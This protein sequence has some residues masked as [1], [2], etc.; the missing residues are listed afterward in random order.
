MNWPK[1]RLG[2]V[3][4][5][6]LGKTPPR[7][8]ARM[9]D[10]THSKGCV[11]SS[12]ADM[13]NLENGC[14][15]DTKEYIS[16]TAVEE[17]DI[18]VVKKGTL[19][20]SFKLTLGR[21]AIAGRDLYTNEAIA[22]LP[23]RDAYAGKVDIDYL[24]TYF[25]FFDWD[26]FARKDEKVLG[27]TLNKKKLAVL[28]VVLPPLA[29]QKKIVEKV[30]KALKRVD[31]LKAQFERMEKSAADYFKAAL[32]ETFA[33]VKGEKVELRTIGDV[34]MCKR[35]LK[36]QTTSVGEIPFYKIGTFGKKA[37]AFISRKLFDE[38]RARYSYPE[39]GDVLLS[40]AGTI[41]RA[42]FFDGEP[43]YFQ[44]SNIV[45]LRHDGKK[46]TNSYLYW[47]YQTS[48]WRITEGTTIHRLY[49]DDVLSAKIKLPSLE[50]QREVV[51]RLTEI[52]CTASRLE[53]AARRCIGICGKMRKAILAEAFQ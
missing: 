32:A 1:V 33:A 6:N 15:V 37:N 51:K 42:V 40:A 25:S 30:E 5:I 8:V 17:C 9:W 18:P 26:E 36:E 22:A 11:W 35:V 20:V 48:P 34:C 3:C 2:D 7:G 52:K 53:E 39:K 43:A 49:N 10:E 45:W 50:I 29:E 19:L 44:D 46:V 21:T 27:K 28:P 24:R 41:G 13:A 14:L 16:K 12:I 31:A 4:E 23:F 47:C 38:F